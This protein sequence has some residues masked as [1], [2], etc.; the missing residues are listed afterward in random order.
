VTSRA[1]ECYD[2]AVNAGDGAR[3]ITTFAVRKL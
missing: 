3:D 1:L 2:A